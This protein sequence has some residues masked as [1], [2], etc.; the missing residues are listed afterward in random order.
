MIKLGKR[1]TGNQFTEPIDLV[2]LWVD[3]SDVEWLKKKQQYLTGSDNLSEEAVNVCRFRDNDE[4]KMS[5]RSVEKHLPWINKIYIVTDNQIPKWLD[6]SN[7]KIKVVFHKD[8][9]PAEVLPTFNSSA[10]ELYLPRI[11]DLSEH[12]IYS[13]DDMFVNC[14]LLPEF[15]FTKDGQPIIRLQ[16]STCKKKADKSTYS[17]MVVKMQELVREKFGK[18]Y[19]LEPHHNFDA[20]TKTICEKCEKEFKNEYA[21]R[22]LN[23]FRVDE[24]THRSLI[25]F[26]ALATNQAKLKIITRTDFH[27]PCGTKIFN[28]LTGRYRVDSKYLGIEKNLLAK[29]FDYVNPKLFCLNDNQATS[30]EN[31][32]TVKRF[33]YSLF[34]NKSSFEKSDKADISIVIPVYN[35]EKYL[36]KCLDSL[37]N[38][39]FKNIEI[40]CVNDGSSDNSLKI[41]G[42]Y[43][44][45][46]KR[47]KIINQENQGVSVARNNG[48]Q[49]ATG[50]YIMFV[51]GDDWIE[52][53]TCEKIYNRITCDGSDVLVFS[54]YDVFPH[55]K[56]PYNLAKDCAKTLLVGDNVDDLIKDIIYVPAVTCGKLY[57]RE[58]LIN[59]SLTF[60]INLELSEDHLFWYNVL[61]KN[62]QISILHNNFYNY[63][64]VRTGNSMESFNNSMARYTIFE[65]MV[66]QSELYNKASE[67]TKALIRDRNLNFF[68]WM[69]MKHKD[70]RDV[71][72]EII[73]LH[74]RDTNPNG[75]NH[76]LAL[77]RL[78]K[79]KPVTLSKK[80]FIQNKISVIIPTIQSSIQL[81]NGLVENLEKD[82]AVEEIIIINNAKPKLDLEGTKVVCLNQKK[83]IFV[84]NS[85]NLGVETS[86]SE[87]FALINDDLILPE[88][89]C[90]KVL[91][92]L[93]KEKGIVGIDTTSVIDIDN[94]L[95]TNNDNYE[96][97][98]NEVSERK[99]SFGIAMFGH[100]ESYYK[101]PK[102]LKIFCGDDYLIYANKKHNKNNYAIQNCKIKHC[103]QLSSG[104]IKFEYIKYLDCKN[105]FKMDKEYK[106][107]ESCRKYNFMDKIIGITNGYENNVK[108]KYL[109]LFGKYIRIGK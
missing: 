94:P 109:V 83:N 60:S 81:L 21:T 41:L 11:P 69:W 65:E 56:K 73:S 86:K 2:Y 100:R 97:H 34:P 14:D 79:Y 46:D 27:L 101:I 8:F 67:S 48:I 64:N 30:I 17:Y 78:K 19:N 16:N 43:A 39:T 75:R 18:F 37:V 38:Q 44:S 91:P 58:F 88:N 5:L 62:P 103:H 3:D 31:R 72:A 89:F 51:D 76:K 35:I 71:L 68:L 15:F 20:Y 23:R 59:N 106:I 107:P 96:I 28:I 74:L 32:I 63:R 47:I 42:E 80:E 95:D 92:Y 13:N 1:T 102:C 54:H 26:Y 7:P 82:P 98:L 4:L 6:T 104:N 90:S 70:K 10:L 99:L 33:M 49:V 9:I 24:D 61:A 87:Y 84:N 22:E 66:L 52:P 57:R 55:K 40:I 53:E 77:K 50:E 25:S 93:S 105:M 108:H 12:F 45:N 29:R 85:W 36:P